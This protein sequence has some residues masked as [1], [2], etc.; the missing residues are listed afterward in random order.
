MLAKH[1]D[2]AIKHNWISITF[3]PLFNYCACFDCLGKFGLSNF[4]C[5]CRWS[6]GPW[7]NGVEPVLVIFEDKREKDQVWSK[8]RDNLRAKTNIVVT[9]DSSTK[10]QVE[11]DEKETTA[12][13]NGTVRKTSKKMAIVKPN[14][15]TADIPVK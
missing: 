14:T 5:V 6:A 1:C 4:I 15:Q 13:K 2:D 7:V 8:L 3:F 10:R 11:I 9:Q 12:Q